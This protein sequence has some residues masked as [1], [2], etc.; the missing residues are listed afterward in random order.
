MDSRQKEYLYMELSRILEHLD[1]YE[2]EEAH[3]QLEGL[4]NEI[5]YDAL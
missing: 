3:V 4:I 1:R 5:K 2:T